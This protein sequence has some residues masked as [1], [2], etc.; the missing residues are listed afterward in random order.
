MNT[1]KDSARQYLEARKAIRNAADPTAF[2]QLGRLYAKGI[3]TS[4]NHVLANYFF[5]KALALGCKEAEAYID[6]EYDTGRRSIVDEILDNMDNLEEIPPYKKEKFVNRVEKERLRKNF[7]IL[8]YIRGYLPYFY[9]DY[10]QQKGFEDIL[11]H[12]NSIDADICYSLCTSGNRSE[13]NLNL[14]SKM[15]QQL[16]AP[17]F[18]DSSLYKLI[19]HCD[20]SIPFEDNVHE[21]YQ[22]LIN[23]RASYEALCGSFGLRKFEIAQVEILDLYPYFKVELIPVLRLQAFRC[24]LSIKDVCPEVSEFMG[25]LESDEQ[26]LDVCEKVVD[27]EIQLFLISYVELNIDIDSMLISLQNML[28]SYWRKDLT[29][30]AEFLNEFVGRLTHAG[31]DHQLP[32]FTKDSLPKISLD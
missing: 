11:N 18:Q 1:D 29:P 14:I 17:V 8:S 32:E 9:P 15:L 12:R 25:C 4:E 26:L 16:F 6:A 21:L 3:G 20:Y 7:G 30:L 24:L 19:V 28:R 2:V 23:M 10:D 27:E 31:I 22:C 5:D 13:V